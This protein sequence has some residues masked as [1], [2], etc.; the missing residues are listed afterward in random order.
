[1][2]NS[3]G[4]KRGKSRILGILRA[5]QSA[6]QRPSRRERFSVLPD[7]S[8]SEDET[9]HPREIQNYESWGTPFGRDTY[10]MELAKSDRTKCKKCFQK[11]FKN[12]LRVG[13]RSPKRPGQPYQSTAWY[14]PSC[15]PIT[16]L[17]YDVWR[18]NGI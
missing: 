5:R 3:G 1:M 13:V 10:I 17:S 18:R 12:E 9:Y 11:I 14:H 6:R 7:S 4:N 8:S 15:F 16:N 2:Y